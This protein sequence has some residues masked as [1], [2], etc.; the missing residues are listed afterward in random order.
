MASAKTVVPAPSN[1]DE[2]PFKIGEHLTVFDAAMVYAGRH[3]AARFL[4]DGSVEDYLHFLRAGISN[5]ARSRQ[6]ARARQ[7][8]DILRELIKR[9][10][11]HTIEPVR[12]AYL[13][14]GE[15]DPTRTLIRT[16]DLASLATERGEQPKYLRYFQAE[17]VSGEPAQLAK[18]E[19]S[20]ASLAAARR[21]GPM[22]GT[23]DRYAKSD[24][25]L[26]AEIE[27]IMRAQQKSAS[28]AAL[29]LAE[30][31]RIQGRGGNES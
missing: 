12:I 16:P 9:I 11:N 30:V 1:S 29:A 14:S 6:R 20:G 2:E 17:A 23:V 15:I 24:R 27:H 25:A 4:K 22:P 3:P 5:H 7:S 18:S 10:Q 28:A 31:G 19:K 21:R 8:W 13:R 26:Y